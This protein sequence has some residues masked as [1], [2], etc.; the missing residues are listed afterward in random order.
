METKTMISK[1]E[2]ETDALGDPLSS[3]QGQLV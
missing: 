2:T 1:P 3:G